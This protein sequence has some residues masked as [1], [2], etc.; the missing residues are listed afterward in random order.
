[1]IQQELE[2]LN[3]TVRQIELY[4]TQM[5][6]EIAVTRR[7]TY[8]AEEN[9]GKQEKEKSEQDVLLDKLHEELKGLKKRFELHEAQLEA[10]RGET[11]AAKSILRE[12]EERMTDINLQKKQRVQLQNEL[13]QLSVDILNTEGHNEKFLETITAMNREL[14]GKGATIEEYE[15]E[16]RRRNDEIEKKTKEVDRLNRQYDRLTSNVEDENL[17]PL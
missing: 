2:K 11:M 7:A 14:A 8:A 3:Q 12:A 13:A 5:K 4:N 6:D 9:I 1:M 15:L 16:I 17:G 10:Q